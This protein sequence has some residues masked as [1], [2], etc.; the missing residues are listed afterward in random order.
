MNPYAFVSIVDAAGKQLAEG[1]VGLTSAAALTRQV[2]TQLPS[3][4]P[5]IF[6]LLQRVCDLDMLLSTL[7]SGQPPRAVKA[8]SERGEGNEKTLILTVQPSRAAPGRSLIA[9]MCGCV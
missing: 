6:L 4:T 7:S 1:E 2:A 3:S 8:E 5:P 9:C